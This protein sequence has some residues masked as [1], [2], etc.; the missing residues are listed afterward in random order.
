IFNLGRDVPIS[1][2]VDK[3]KELKPDIVGLSAMMSTTM[4]KMRETIKEF[5]RQGVR[6]GIMIVVGGACVTPEFA[7]EIRADGYAADA[8]KAVRLCEKLMREKNELQ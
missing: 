1:V 8:K 2:Y 5:E 3:M 4:M 6:D 7:E